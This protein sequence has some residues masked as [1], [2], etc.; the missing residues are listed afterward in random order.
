MSHPARSCALLLAVL[1]LT[2]FLLG[3]CSR[4]T[5]SPTA[6]PASP[7]SRDTD[8]PIPSESA[9]PFQPSSTPVPLAAVVNGAP[10]DLDSYQADLAR[11]Q[12]AKGGEVTPQEKQLV[13]N[14]LVDQLLLAQAAA[15]QG[16]TPD[17]AQVQDRINGLVSH[18]GSEKA[19]NDWMAAQGYTLETFQKDL[20]SS[21]AA[22]WMRDQI[23]AEVPT[24]ADQVHARQIL[25][26]DSAKADEALAEL[27]S[28]K[29]FA[30]EAAKYD[31]VTK[32][33]LGWFP[34]GYLLDPRL[35]EVIFNLEPGKYSNAVET[36]AGF[37][38]IQ[39][40][41][42]DP[43]R[44]LDPKARL[45]LQSQAVSSWLQTRRSQSQVQILI[46]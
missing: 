37:H 38:I 45:A 34:R 35:D 33:D 16:F 21:M 14:N 18:L 5:G 20:T 27:Q 17:A 40:I 7:V 2:A 28:G 41:E 42:R 29:D 43:Q 24:S 1:L 46:P 12:A 8:Q 4:G 3:A 30:T 26:Y 13:L 6:L 36:A 23:I 39:L 9:T 15:E 19:L 32:G 25:L 44:P 11:Y 31:P 22:A 10:I